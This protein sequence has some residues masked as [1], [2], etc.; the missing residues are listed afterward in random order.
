MVFRLSENPPRTAQLVAT[1]VFFLHCPRAQ[2]WG[3]SVSV[4]EVRHV[5]DM[6]T[7]REHISIEMQSGDT[8]TLEAM[9]MRVELS[10]R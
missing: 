5:I 7:R 6:T 10:P 1:Q 4:N 2:P 8:I 9:R 3:S